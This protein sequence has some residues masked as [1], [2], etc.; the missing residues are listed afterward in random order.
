LKKAR[1][2]SA[3]TAILVL[4]TA[5][6]SYAQVNSDF[7]KPVARGPQSDESVYFIMTDRF[8]NG[9]TSNDYGGTNKSL[10]VSGFAPED[11]G[12]WHGGDFKGITKRLDYI[13]SMG[14]TSLWITP[15]VVQKS[16]QGNSAAYH[17]YWGIDFTTVDPHL[18]SEEDFKELVAQAHKL[19][20][21]VIIDVVV[22]HTADVIYYDNSGRP[23]VNAA[24]ANIK[25]PDWLNLMSNYHNLGNN[26]SIGNPVLDGDFYGL[27]DL[28]T[29]NPK[30]ISGWIDV[31]SN[32]ITKFDIDGMRI[33]TF[34]HVN[35]EFWK[36][37]IP[38]IQAVALAAGKKDFPI[39]GEA[40]DTDAQS[41]STYVAGGEVPSV[42]D[43]DFQK[44]V[45]S[46]AQFGVSAEGLAEL[47]NRDDLYTTSTTSAYGL[48]TFLGNHDMGRI[49]YFLSNA[50]SPGE[51][52]PLLE[53]AKLANALLF[54]L[55][56]GPVL[57]YGDEKGMTGTGGDKKARQDMFATQVEDWQNEVRI[58]SSPI[59]SASAFDVKNP[60]EDQISELQKVIAANP[61][62]RN[63]TQE[64]R[65][66]KGGLFVATRYLNGA[67]YIVAL[68]GSDTPANAQFKV[69][70]LKGDWDVISGS[71][72]ISSDGQMALAIVQRTYC[73]AKA[74]TPLSNAGAVKISTPK[75]IQT[76][77]PSGWREVSAQ[78]SGSSYSEVTFSVRV[79]G[80]KWKSIGTADRRTF[81]TDGT[82]GGFYRVYLHPED[83]KKGS[84][85]EVIAAT[86]D[87]K[88]KVQLS[89]IV[90]VKI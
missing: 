68:N 56:G 21:R 23:Q 8:E 49:G 6:N 22:N 26:P 80:G 83:F 39:F 89:K 10:S 84:T 86:V 62:L 15:P 60:L 35:P 71:C 65:F 67:E 73:V 87:A 25:K 40:S 88:N 50:V 54:L 5:S 85:V 44:Q 64:V 38:K 34:K 78:V 42:L 19:N 59:K 7:I 75:V 52:Q 1:L 76:S 77:L 63:G 31:W 43:F 48:A 11:I 27:D 51:S 17:G 24:E 28:E 41:L 82:K 70:S 46:F 30:V 90:K 18:G 57:Y 47:F 33:D 16:V 81:A 58:G 13:K 4:A 14:F 72:T 36:A 66:A 20:M 69:G 37:F 61:A 3:L 55:R 2:L 29:E 74:K 45:K 12:W 79:K 53:R 32:W 9:D